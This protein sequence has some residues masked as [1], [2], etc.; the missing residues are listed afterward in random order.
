MPAGSSVSKI[1]SLLIGSVLL[2]IAFFYLITGCIE[3]RDLSPK[4]E[5]PIVA[6]IDG[7]AL[8]QEEFELLIPE[9]YQSLVTVEEK[10]AYLQRWITTELLYKEAQRRG[11]G[12]S[13]DIRIKLNQYKKDLL[14]D[15]LVQQVIQKHAVVSDEEVRS[16]YLEHEKEYTQ[17]FRVSHILMNSADDAEKIY[18]LLKK[19]SFYWVAKKYSMDKHT[20]RGGDLGFLS[21]GNMMP[22]FEGAVFQMSVGDISDV[23]ESEFGYHIIKLT[24]IRP[25]RNKLE[26]D[27][28]KDEIAN[29]LLMEKRT[30]VYDS[31]VTS[32]KKNTD[33]EILDRELNMQTFADSLDSLAVNNGIPGDSLW[34]K[35]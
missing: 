29:K 5:Q 34:Q 33:I 15:R 35:N 13:P 3:R 21:K 30:D 2:P 23:I 27:D 16:Y 12:V 11:M 31:L 1:G 18:K 14:A 20:R 7:E 22:E 25:A 4:D 26:Y 9:D 28:V 17:E 32:L 24:D 19:S 6:R 10:Q 8:S